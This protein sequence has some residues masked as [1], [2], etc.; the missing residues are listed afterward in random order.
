MSIRTGIIKAYRAARDGKYREAFRMLKIYGYDRTALSPS[1]LSLDNGSSS[2]AL[3]DLAVMLDGNT[4]HI[5][6]APGAPGMSLTLTFTAVT[7]IYGL[8]L[9]AYYSGSSTHY[10]ALQLYNYTT[11]AWDTFITVEHSNGYNTRYIRVPSDTNYISGGAAQVR[12][13]HPSSGNASHD[14]YIDYVGIEP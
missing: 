8:V 9:R 4:Y 14:A 12:W 13:L 7:E 10:C 5:D 11:T 3:A 6:E 2:D 1:S